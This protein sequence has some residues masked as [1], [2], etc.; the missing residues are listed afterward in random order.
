MF[1]LIYL[2]CDDFQ[3][4]NFLFV[5]I[6]NPDN[7]FAKCNI[8]TCNGF[9]TENPRTVLKSVRG[10]SLLLL[11]LIQ[12][13]IKGKQILLRQRDASHT[14]HAGHTQNGKGADHIQ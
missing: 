11:D 13:G 2:G 4:N 1:S 10:F 3:R 14:D 9:N 8:S 7:G 5:C 6:T 12:L